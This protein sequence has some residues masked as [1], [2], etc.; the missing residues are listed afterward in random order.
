M[1]LEEAQEI[2]K[3]RYDSLYS[4]Y[5]MSD[6]IEDIQELM[7]GTYFSAKNLENELIGFFCFGL[8][9]QINAKNKQL[10]YSDKTALDIGL[11][12]RPDLTG[13][14]KGKDFLIEGILFAQ[15]QYTFQKLRLSVAAFNKRAISLYE[16]V[17][18]V[19]TGELINKHNKEVFFL[20]ES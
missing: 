20:M 15:K 10:V 12:L 13:Q 16:K 2:V 8:N 3:W 4:R 18:F 5:D 17:G 19:I 7:D 14:G 9:A 11:G 1:K 6:D